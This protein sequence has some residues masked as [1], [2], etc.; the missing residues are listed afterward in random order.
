MVIWLFILLCLLSRIDSLSRQFLRHCSTSEGS[1]SMYSSLSNQVE[2][3]LL[4]ETLKQLLSLPICFW[5]KWS[6][7]AYESSKV[8]YQLLHANVALS[9]LDTG[10]SAICDVKRM[11]R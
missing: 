1:L 7:K 4:M 9:S 6:R 5:K 3:D 10:S 2:L 8:L 11:H